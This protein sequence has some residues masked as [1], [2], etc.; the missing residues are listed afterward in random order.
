[1]TAQSTALAPI[2]SSAYLGWGL[3]QKLEFAQHLCKADMLPAAYR[4]KPANVLLAVEL[5][6]ALAIPPITAIQLVHVIEGKPSASSALIASLVRRAGHRLR[7]KGDNKSCTV[8]IVRCDDPDFTFEVT[9]TIEMAR[10]A[11]LDKKGTWKAYPAAML[12]ARATTACARRACQEALCGVQYSPEELGAR[13]DAE[14]EVI[15]RDGEVVIEHEPKQD[16]P[17]PAQVKAL[18]SLDKLA[19]VRFGCLGDDYLAW[20][21]GR[22]PAQM[23]IPALRA[24]YAEL[25]DYKPA[26]A[27]SQAEVLEAAERKRLTARFHALCKDLGMTPD[28]AKWAIHNSDVKLTLRDGQPSL[29]ASAIDVLAAACSLLSAY[30]EDD[31]EQAKHAYN[32]HCD[33][34]ADF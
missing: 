4:N 14:G 2:Q 21:A 10:E 12:E 23:T 5:G 6:Q 3:T 26:T 34:V 31:A 24:L 18:A 8:Q 27:P 7:V 15:I 29:S 30:T 20:L 1:M 19:Q 9:W 32:D 33:N 28:C 16:G 11:G 22:E 13:V 17:D 25:R